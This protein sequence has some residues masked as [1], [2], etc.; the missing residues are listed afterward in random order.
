MSDDFLKPAWS[1]DLGQPIGQCRAVPVRLGSGGGHDGIDAILVVVGGDFDVDPFSEMFFLPRDTLKLVLLD[2]VDG[3]VI[4]RQDLGRGVIP[5]MWFCPVLPFDLDG[6]GVDEIWLVTGEPDHPMTAYDAK[7]ERRDAATGEITGR[8]KW[9]IKFGHEAMSSVYRRFLMPAFVHGEAVLVAGQGTYENMLLTAFDAQMNQRWQTEMTADAPGARGSHMCAIVDLDGD[10][11]DEVLWGERV[12]RLSDGRELFCCDRDVYRGH[13]D[14]V[15]PIRLDDG[16]WRI[17]TCREDDYEASP[18]VVMF[19]GE[20]RRLWGHVDRGHIDMGWTARI[21]PGG[22]LVTTAIKIGKKTCGPDGRFHQAI[23]E[24]AFD[25]ITGEPIELGFS[26]YRTL[27]VDLDGDG[28]HELV[29]GQASGGGEVLDSD[30]NLLFDLGGPVAMLSRFL[31]LPGEQLLSYHADGGLTAWHCPGAVDTPAATVRY[32]DATY[33]T[34]Q[35]LTSSG[36]NLINLGG[37]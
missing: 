32:A 19:D 5:G 10:G 36:Y 31:D 21:G 16:S 18:R 34:N 26:H 1:V 14:V 30:G 15:Q 2:A 23:E 12:I 20:G 37:L 13:S 6:D 4:W 7:L 17:F 25:T 22:R 11:I 28:R 3:S 35:R 33:R 29:R 24:F 27:P 8:W 9:P